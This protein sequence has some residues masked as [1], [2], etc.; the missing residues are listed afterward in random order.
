MV[1]VSHVLKLWV[2]PCTFFL[3]LLKLE[4][5][6]STRFFL[7]VAPDANSFL[8]LLEHSLDDPLENIWFLTCQFPPYSGFLEFVVSPWQFCCSICYCEYEFITFFVLSILLSRW[9][10]VDKFLMHPTFPNLLNPQS[11]DLLSKFPPR[12]THT[13]ERSWVILSCIIHEFLIDLSPEWDDIQKLLE[14]K[15][16]ALWIVLQIVFHSE[17][18]RLPGGLKHFANSNSIP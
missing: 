12:S 16:L 9:F 8:R 6:F 10:F 7:E 3:V 18:S 5:I 14:K 15:L 2:A 13:Q 11:E 1:R 17:F 4:F